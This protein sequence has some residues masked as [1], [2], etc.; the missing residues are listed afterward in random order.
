MKII[1]FA[2]GLVPHEVAHNKPLD[3]NLHCLTTILYTQYH[4]A[5]TI[6]IFLKSGR[7]EFLPSTSLG[8]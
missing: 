3:L 5:W 6:Y 2:N 4:I 8:F 7:H 1:K